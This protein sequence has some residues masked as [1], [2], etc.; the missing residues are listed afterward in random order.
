[1]CPCI[2]QGRANVYVTTT[3]MRISLAATALNIFALFAQDSLPSRHQHE[4]ITVVVPLVGAGTYADPKR[5]LFAPLP[6]EPSNPEGIQS[7]EWLPSDDGKYAVVEFVA[8]DRKALQPILT[9]AR[10]VKA[11]EKG[12]VKKTDAESELKVY[13]KD[14]TFDAAGKAK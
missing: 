9:D 5:P 3:Y 8:F 7:F 13:R 6:S 12:K 4:R 2:L 11:F 1:V 14:F 10:V